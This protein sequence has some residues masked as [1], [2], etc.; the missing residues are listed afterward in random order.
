[1]C[2]QILHFVQDDN[3]PT[4]I[5]QLSSCT[6]EDEVPSLASASLHIT[7]VTI[8][9]GEVASRV[10]YEGE[11]TDSYNRSVTGFE[12]GDKLGMVYGFGTFTNK[13]AY[14]TKTATGWSITDAAGNA[15]D[16]RPASGEKWEDFTGSVLYNQNTGIALTDELKDAYGIVQGDVPATGDK[17]ENHMYADMLRASTVSNDGIVVDTDIYSP[18]LGAMTIELNHSYALLRL[19]VADATVAQG[20]YLV[21]GKEYT[22]PELATLWAQI[23]VDSH[24]YYIPLTKVTV[25]NVE[26]WQAIARLGTLTGFKAVMQCG[27]ETFTLDLP[28]KVGTS[29]EASAG[30]TLQANTRYLLTLSIS[31]STSTVTLTGADTKPGWGDESE[32]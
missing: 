14:L 24:T 17:I 8:D 15:L 9:G 32:I 28:F 30:L 2:A 31:P 18:T 23:T 1:M 3:P 12:E 21:D 13:T 6:S 19:P 25:G 4:F 16:I 20:T 26:Y 10:A 7:S 27:E 5:F 22:N 29:T 11:G